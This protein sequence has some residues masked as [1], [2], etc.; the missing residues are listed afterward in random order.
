MSDTQCLDPHCEAIL[1]EYRENL[2]RFN[3][4]ARQL[5]SRL[6]NTF[7]D[8]GLLVAALEYRVKTEG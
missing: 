7:D 8:A 1:E 2:P 4:M 3:D 6:K 5:H